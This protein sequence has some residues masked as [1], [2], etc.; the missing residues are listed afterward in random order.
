M[1]VGSSQVIEINHFRFRLFIEELLGLQNKIS[2][3]FIYENGVLS[4]ILGN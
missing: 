4:L 3:L 2:W 1:I